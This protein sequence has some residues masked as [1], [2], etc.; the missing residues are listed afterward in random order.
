MGRGEGAVNPRFFDSIYSFDRTHFLRYILKFSR[1]LDVFS[2]SYSH[3][4]TEFLPENVS[5]D[6][7][8]L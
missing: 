8:S 6:V 4:K 7:P 1:C 3:R 5:L 2:L